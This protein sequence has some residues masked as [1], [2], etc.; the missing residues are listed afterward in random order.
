MYLWR[1]AGHRPWNK[2]V[3]SLQR[4]S[5]T[6]TMTSA[7]TEATKQHRAW[8]L[9]DWRPRFKLWLEASGFR[10]YSEKG[11]KHFLRKVRKYLPDL[12]VLPFQHRRSWW[13]MCWSS[14][15]LSDHRC[16]R[17]G[18]TT[19]TSQIICFEMLFRWSYVVKATPAKSLLYYVLAERAVS[20]R[21]SCRW[22]FVARRTTSS[23]S[24]C[25]C[26]AEHG[27]WRHSGSWKKPSGEIAVDFSDRTLSQWFL[28]S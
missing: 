17:S 8:A 28:F 7:V 20:L 2:S 15:P 3:V 25:S 27:G 11:G 23:L 26:I 1:R 12:H 5:K 18:P 14:R 21:A 9:D 10:L 19:G 22:H 6:D 13:G 4:A 24:S 16:K